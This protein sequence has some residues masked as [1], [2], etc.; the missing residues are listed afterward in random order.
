MK[1]IKLSFWSVYR[2][3]RNKDLYLEEFDT[4]RKA[5]NFCKTHCFK[6][7]NDLR[8]VVVYD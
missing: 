8:V 2:N 4:L 5:K 3:S 7:V 1:A 6:T